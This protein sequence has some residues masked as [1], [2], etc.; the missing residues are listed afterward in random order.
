MFLNSNF[1]QRVNAH[2]SKFKIYKRTDLPLFHPPDE[3]PL[4]EFIFFFH[5]FQ[6]FQILCTSGGIYMQFLTS[7]F[8][9]KLYL[10]ESFLPVHKHLS[11]SF[12]KQL[13]CS[14]LVDALPLDKPFPYGQT[15]RLLAI[16]F[17]QVKG[18][19]HEHKFNFIVK[20]SHIHQLDSINN[21][22]L[23]IA[24]SHIYPCLL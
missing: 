14:K 6:S 7:Y 2:D 1:E 10:G 12:F 15:L 9:S 17:S 3:V 18:F 8:T 24:L 20:H 22:L 13:Q 16:L 4:T 11:F 23:Y 19:K 21:I 5:F